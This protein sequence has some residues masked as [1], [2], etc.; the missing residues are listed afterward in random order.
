M[1]NSYMINL[2]LLILFLASSILESSY[3]GNKLRLSDCRTACQ[4]E[5]D[6]IS[7]RDIKEFSYFSLLIFWMFN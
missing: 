2:N 1:G 6:F 3:L 7:G 5:S 4:K